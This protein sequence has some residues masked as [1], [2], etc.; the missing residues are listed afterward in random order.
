M[1]EKGSLNPAEK[2]FGENVTNSV[3]T[4]IAVIKVVCSMRG[5]LVFWFR[6]LPGVGL[7]S[8]VSLEFSIIF[9]YI[10]PEI[11]RVGQHFQSFYVAVAL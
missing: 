4:T 10:L 2:E 11:L 9:D 3:A 6:S 8:V 1:A 7:G 5:D